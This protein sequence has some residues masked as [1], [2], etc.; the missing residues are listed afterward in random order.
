M[1][2]GR[3]SLWTEQGQTVTEWLMVAGVFTA[4]VVF[5]LGIVPRALGVFVRGL[6]IGVR[7]IAP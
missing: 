1:K 6:A 3:R 5:M 2:T 4:F 7:T